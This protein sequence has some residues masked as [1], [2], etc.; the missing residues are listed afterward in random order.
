MNSRKKINKHNGSNCIAEKLA[1]YAI[2][3]NGVV[4]HGSTTYRY[5]KETNTLTIS[6][7]ITTE[8]YNPKIYDDDLIFPFNVN[9]CNENNK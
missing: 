9:E 3:T 5:D 7:G 4:K 8:Y 2:R 6:D 1:C